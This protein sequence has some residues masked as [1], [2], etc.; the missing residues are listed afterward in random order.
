MFIKFY[1]NFKILAV[2]LYSFIQIAI[3]L[4]LHVGG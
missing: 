4:F 1:Y 2:G 3:H